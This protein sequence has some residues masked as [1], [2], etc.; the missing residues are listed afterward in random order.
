MLL[1]ATTAQALFASLA[2]HLT[3]C[4]PTHEAATAAKGPTAAEALAFLDE[5][6]KQY[7]TM[8][9]EGARV[10][11]VNATY[12][13]FDTDWLVANVDARTTELRVKYAKTAATFNGVEVP[14]DARRKLELLKRDLR[15]PAPERPGAARELADITTRLESTYGTGKIDFEGRTMPQ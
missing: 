3:A 14:T 15:L 7:A 8:Y 5:V 2:I 4:A 12:I 6:E 1:K 9:E 11:W 10:G 13:N